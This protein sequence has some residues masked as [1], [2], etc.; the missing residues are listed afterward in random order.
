MQKRNGVGTFVLSFKPSFF[1]HSL[2]NITSF[3]E[4]V[5]SLGLKP[6]TQF[7]KQEVKEASGEIAKTLMLK[8]EK[9]II[10]TTR[11]RI[12]DNIPLIIERSHL[13]YNEFKELISMN[14]ELEGSLYKILTDKFGIN[15]YRSVQ[16][17]QAII[18]VGENARLLKVKK[19]SPGIFLTSIIY[20]VD[21]IPIEVLHAIYRGDRYV[22]QVETGQYKPSLKV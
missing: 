8:G 6:K 22:F 11:L 18:L 13:P 15:L 17:F 19:G 3:A 1:T 10:I 7:L 2:K 21:N 5:E 9:K 20:D 12:A 16:S 14:M 4:D